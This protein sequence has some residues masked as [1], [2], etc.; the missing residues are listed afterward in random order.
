MIQNRYE[1]KNKNA[2]ILG[3][4]GVVPSIIFALR[5]MKVSKILI[6]NRTRKKAEELKKI[7]KDLEIIDWG[8]TPNFDIAINATS[9]GLNKEDEIKLDLTNIGKDKF[10]YTL[11]R[12]L[13]CCNTVYTIKKEGKKYDR[14]MYT[15][16]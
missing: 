2:L 3:A 13:K 15:T 11:P 1:I 7:Y 12:F 9:V 10:F 16:E 5:K 8:K 4:G 6:S 14:M